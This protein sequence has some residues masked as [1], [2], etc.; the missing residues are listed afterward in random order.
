[1]NINAIIFF[2]KETFTGLKRSSLMTFIAIATVSIS[3]I[4]LGLFLLISVNLGKV[5]QI[6]H[7]NLKYDFFLNQI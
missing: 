5:T 3:L 4:I 1:M 2:L 6:L 7:Q